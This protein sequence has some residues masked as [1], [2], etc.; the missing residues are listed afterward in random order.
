MW[1]LPFLMC[2]IYISVDVICSTASILNLVAISF[3]RY[4]QLGVGSM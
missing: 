4:V 3:D 1:E 2:D